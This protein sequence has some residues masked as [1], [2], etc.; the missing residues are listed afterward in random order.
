MTEQLKHF[1]DNGYVVIEGALSPEEVKTINDGMDA[2]ETAIRRTGRW[3]E[4]P[5]HD[6]IGHGVSIL[7]RIDVFDRVI[8]HPNT[9][10]LIEAI[11]GKGVRFSSFSFMR[12]EACD[13]DAPEDIDDDPLALSRLWHREYG[14]ICE[15]ADQNDY[16][17]S[18][19]QT[20]YYLD[21]VDETTHCTSIIPESAETKR[22]RPKKRGEST[23]GD[24]PLM[25]ADGETAYVHPEKPRWMDSFGRE[26]PRRIGGVDVHAPAGSAVMFNLLNYHCATIRKTKR[27]RRA[28]HAVYRQPEPLHLRHALNDFES[29][30]AFQAALPKRA[31]L[32]LA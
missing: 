19:I 25:I 8:Y 21:D 15:G 23:W 7:H 17:A 31:A 4:R 24:N 14:G 5:G 13:A 1:A 10:P 11:L 22:H 30:A 32:S 28:I 9:W 29:V 16:F 26:R 20:I 6:A 27:I 18:G 2:D 3:G 12:R